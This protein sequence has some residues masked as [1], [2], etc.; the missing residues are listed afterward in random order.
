MEEHT[1]VREVSSLYGEYGLDVGQSYQTWTLVTHRIPKPPTKKE[2]AKRA[3]AE[4]RSQRERAKVEK[5]HDQSKCGGKD[6]CSICFDDYVDA[7]E[8]E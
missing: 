1:D 8:S 7:M 2:L 6:N 4:R 3:T 5:L